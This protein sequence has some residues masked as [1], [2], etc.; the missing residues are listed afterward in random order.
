MMLAGRRL[1]VALVTNHVALRDAIRQA[2]PGRHRRGGRGSP[3]RDC[4]ATWGSR[5]RAS[6][7]PASTPRRRGGRLRRRGVAHRGARGRAGPRRRAWTPTARFPPDSV[8]FRA[9]AGR[10]RRGGGALPRPGAHP[11]EAARRR[12]GRPCGERDARAALRAHQPRPRGGLGPGRNGTGQRPE[13]AG[14]APAGRRDRAPPRHAR[15]PGEGRRGAAGPWP[16]LPPDPDR[17]PARRPGLHRRLG[18]T[19]LLAPLVAGE[20][21]ATGRG[22]P[23]PPLPGRRRG[24]REVASR[25]RRPRRRA[26]TR[27]WRAT[28]G[29]AAR[30]SRSRWSARCAGAAP[31]P[32]PR[33]PIPPSTGPG[34]PSTS[35]GP[36]ATST[37]PPAA[38]PGAST[39]GSSSCAIRSPAPPSDSPRV[40]ARWTARW[41]SCAAPAT[42]ISRCRCRPSAT[43]CSTPWAPPTATTR[44]ATPV[45]RTAWPTRA[46]SP[47]SPRFTPSGWRAR[48]RWVRARTAAGVARGAPGR[49]GD[50]ARDRLDPVVTA[51]PPR[52]MPVRGAGAPWVRLVAGGAGPRGAYS[53]GRGKIGSP[54][55]RRPAPRAPRAP[56]GRTGPRG[57]RSP[58]DAPPSR[59]PRPGAG[60][61]SRRPDLPHEA[62]CS[63][64]LRPGR[65]G[66]PW[67]ARARREAHDAV[68][69]PG[70]RRRS[71]GGVPG[72]HVEQR[73]EESARR[74]QAA[75]AAAGLGPAGGR[76]SPARASLAAAPP[77]RAPGTGDALARRDP[78]P[79]TLRK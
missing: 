75:C 57:A 59:A 27:R 34:T 62:R 71:S 41:P 53:G 50:G 48:W 79:F 77:H 47:S 6:P 54:L 18:R 60:P 70:T 78:A 22:R 17:A 29:P 65:P 20:L 31:S 44:G 21:G 13:H 30:R 8:F 15:P 16:D 11:G 76:R 63:R 32:S 4:G 37:G 42:A 35:G 40:P 66:A 56:G 23:G 25:R 52:G 12:G 1:R 19:P 69:E 72:W 26:S 51:G 67:L 28:G 10:V 24:R 64:R 43:S 7:W 45:R 39:S 49:G 3:P 33:R 38:R 74:R 55:R 61:A 36:C 46:A 58:F 73:T 5:A 68:G 9:A 2:H 14:G